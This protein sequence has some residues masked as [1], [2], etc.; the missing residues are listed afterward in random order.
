MHIDLHDTTDSDNTEFLPAKNARDGITNEPW[1][2][3]K[4]KLKNQISCSC[5]PHLLIRR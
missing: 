1:N 5:S 3:Y 4:G 2:V